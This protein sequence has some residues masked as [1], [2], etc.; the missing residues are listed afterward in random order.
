MLNFK[1]IMGI[2]KDG[3]LGPIGIIWG[4]KN[5]VNKITKYLNKKIDPN[6]QY[7]IAIA[8]SISEEN[9]ELLRKNL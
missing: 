4:Q 2:K 7:D 9:A 3:G 6:K 5:I 8:H 1:P